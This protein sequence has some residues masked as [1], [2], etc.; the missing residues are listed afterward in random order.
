MRE[1]GK[2]G[3]TPRV[4][5]WATSRLAFSMEKWK[6]T[7]GEGR[8]GWRERRQLGREGKGEM[9]AIRRQAAAGHPSRRAAGGGRRGPG[10]QKLERWTARSSRIG[11]CCWG[12]GR[13]GGKDIALLGGGGLTGGG[14]QDYLSPGMAGEVS[15]LDSAWRDPAPALPHTPVSISPQLVGGFI[16]TSLS[17]GP[18]TR[19]LRDLPSGG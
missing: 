4:W 3:V 11:G 8:R 2:S 17:Q 19:D 5:A 7:R 13:T 15:F 16:S 18:G 9:V 12:A 10:L 14:E 6:L 1:G